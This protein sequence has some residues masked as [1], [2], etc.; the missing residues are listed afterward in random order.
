MLEVTA[1]SKNF[2]SLQAV[3][4][5]SFNAKQGEILGFLGPNGAGKSTT[6]KIITG[7]LAPSRGDAFIC[8]KS[9][10]KETLKAQCYLGYA[11]ENAPLYDD[12]Y[13]REFLRF[14]ARIRRIPEGEVHKKVDDVV[15]MCALGDVHLQKIETLSKGYK[16]RV[17]LAQSLVH[18][19]KVLIL[20]EPTDGLDPNQKYAV[21]DLIK[22]LSKEKCILISTHI[23]EEVEEVCDRCII[24]GGGE[25]LFTGTPSELKAKSDKGRMQDVFRA[26][27][28]GA[29]LPGVRV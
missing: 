25:K 27:T 13:V 5:I 7:F 2:G 20:D 18:D 28:T 24:I 1:V 14:V 21:R 4:G 11:P 15:E 12:M 16:R 22:K 23:L 3:R 29:K 17:S 19:P 6:M 9:I 10:T 8:G 26:I